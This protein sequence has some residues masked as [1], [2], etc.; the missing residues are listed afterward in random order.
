MMD[1]QITQTPRSILTERYLRSLLNLDGTANKT[2][3]NSEPAA[4]RIAGPERNF[5]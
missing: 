3:K 4:P 5:D 1:I 2:P